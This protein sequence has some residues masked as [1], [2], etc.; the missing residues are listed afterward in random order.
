MSIRTAGSRRVAAIAAAIISAATAASLATPAFADSRVVA[1]I[2][3]D[4][5]P[6][7]QQLVKNYFGRSM[8]TAQVIYV[9]NTDEHAHLDAYVPAEQIGNETYS[10]SLISPTTSGG[11]HVRT[12]NLTYVTADMLASAFSTAGVRNCDVIAICPFRVSGTGALTGIMMAYE[13]ASGTQLDAAKKDVATQELVVTQK[14]ADQ[15]GPDVATLIV[16]DV[17]ADVIQNGVTNTD[18]VND[19]VDNSVK[20]VTNLVNNVTNNVTNVDNS[21]TTVDDSTTVSNV[22]IDNGVQ[23]SDED[24]AALRNLAQ[25]YAQGGFDYEDMAQTAK[26]VSDNAAASAG[27]TDPMADQ[28]GKA[29]DDAARADSAAEDETSA[30]DASGASD[31]SGASDAAG[32]FD[33]ADESGMANASMP[34]VSNESGSIFAGTD[35][36]AFGGD[37]PVTQTDAGSSDDPEHA[38]DAPAPA[39]GSDLSPV[40]SFDA[41]ELLDGTTL[42]TFDEGGKVGI[43]DA[44]DRRLTDAAYADVEADGGFVIAKDADGRSWILDASGRSVSKDGYDSVRVLGSNW[45]T[46]ASGDEAD[47][48][49]RDDDGSLCVVGHVSASDAASAKAKGDDVK[50]AGVLYGP[51]FSDVADGEARSAASSPADDAGSSAAKEAAPRPVSGTGGRL[52][53]QRVGDDLHLVG[54]DGRDLLGGAALSSVTASPD[55]KTVV[56]VSADGQHA[57]AYTLASE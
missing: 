17:K 45:A 15:V 30:A 22:T 51:D 49:R 28:I 47:V 13:T 24:V 6:D 16:N 23:L 48:V 19:I 36:V 7:Q 35:S 54:P 2:G 5:T 12:A 44:S 11:I 55:G 56:C 34:G 8:E 32:S 46:G 29:A 31:S 41:A 18:E 57:W 42:R 21:V 9:T 52:L 33:A 14:L 50:I 53:T 43:A 37:V 39:D 10:C 25:K 3:A 26:T 1:T 38:S 27:V 40:S 4:L 20:N